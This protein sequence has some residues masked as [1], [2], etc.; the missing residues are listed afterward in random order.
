MLSG[1]NPLE[2][3]DI[4]EDET[5]GQCYPMLLYVEIRWME[6][7]RTTALNFGEAH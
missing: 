5:T 6:V 4:Q 3:S 7:L 2:I 1:A